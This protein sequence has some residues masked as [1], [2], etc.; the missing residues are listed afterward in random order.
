MS[1]Q[2]IQ[3]QQLT[4]QSQTNL[5]KLRAQLEQHAPALAPPPIAGAPS[6]PLQRARP[7]P[8]RPRHGPPGR[9]R[10]GLVEQRCRQLAG[11]GRQRNARRSAVQLALDQLHRGS[12]TCRRHVTAFQDLL[13]KYPQCRHRPRAQFYLARS[14]PKEKAR[15]DSGSRFRLPAGRGSVSGVASGADRAI[16]ARNHPR[17]RRQNRCCQ[18]CVP[19]CR[20]QIPPS[21]DEAVLARD[22]LREQGSS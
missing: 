6:P 17:V 2:L 21:Q 8:P 12:T 11:R 1:Q 10:R 16:Q 20:Q 5:Q 3:I 18:D 15:P 14:L 7:R 22:H 4:G 13:Q 19:G 9:R